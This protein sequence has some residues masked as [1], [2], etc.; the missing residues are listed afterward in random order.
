MRGCMGGARFAAA[1][2]DA[3]LAFFLLLC[4]HPPTAL[5]QALSSTAV[6]GFTCMFAC[7]AVCRQ[8]GVEAH[9]F[10]WT[11]MDDSREGCW[12]GAGRRVHY[13]GAARVHAPCAHVAAMAGRRVSRS[14]GVPCSDQIRS[15]VGSGC[16]SEPGEMVGGGLAPSLRTRPKF[17][18]APCGAPL[19]AAGLP[20]L[21]R[22]LRGRRDLPIC[23]VCVVDG[24][25]TV[26]APIVVPEPMGSELE[27]GGP[28]G[29]LAGRPEWHGRAWR[30]VY[31]P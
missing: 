13:I 14:Q 1:V 20:L 5:A 27:P 6:R 4:A 19:R 7:R 11:H 24:C 2:I 15:V 10:D 16:P 9:S 12:A 28:C 17:T 29:G 22:W 25:H 3:S 26:M 23:C 8:G 31:V 21:C 30:H 18:A